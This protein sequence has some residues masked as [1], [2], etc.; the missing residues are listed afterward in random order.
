MRTPKSVTNERGDETMVSPQFTAA[1]FG[2]G[3]RHVHRDDFARVVSLLIPAEGAQPVPTATPPSP[4][5]LAKAAEHC[6]K[7]AARFPGEALETV[8]TAVAFRLRHPGRSGGRG[9]LLVYAA[10]LLCR[11]Q[12]ALA[13]AE[14]VTSV[15]A[16]LESRSAG[17]VGSV[18]E[19]A[20]PAPLR[21]TTQI[22]LDG[23]F[24]R[25]SR[26]SG[27]LEGDTTQSK[28]KFGS[29]GLD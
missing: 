16:V 18:L 21:Y 5:D 4:Q 28:H 9:A 15:S 20:V 27:P 23:D 12:E 24:V 14:A 7:L 13:A 3:R 10:A 19:D 22:T 11:E 25:G 6:A 8:A 17:H 26:K 2:Y 29:V 1:R